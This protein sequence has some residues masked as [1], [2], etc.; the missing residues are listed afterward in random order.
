MGRFR[1]AG[2]QSN[3]KDT[4]RTQP[5]DTYRRNLGKNELK[6]KTVGAHTNKH[7]HIHTHML[8]DAPQLTAICMCVRPPESV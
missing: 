3:K 1:D 5:L 7:T 8:R 2:K 6:S 4:V